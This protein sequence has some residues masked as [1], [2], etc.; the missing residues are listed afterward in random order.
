MPMSAPAS[1]EFRLPPPGGWFASIVGHSFLLATIGLA[2]WNLLHAT[3]IPWQTLVASVLWPSLIALWWYWAVGFDEGFER[4]VANRQSEFSRN[5]FV[6][7]SSSN[8]APQ[9]ISVGFSFHGRDRF[10]LDID[11]QGL[12]TISWSRGQASAMAERD[13]NDWQ[14]AL[15]CRPPEGSAKVRRPGMRDEDIWVF[16]YTGSRKKISRLG[17]SLVEFLRSC[18]LQ[19]EAGKDA[20]EYETPRRRALATLDAPQGASRFG[21]SLE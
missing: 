14:L 15:W 19:L 13:F 16:P 17:E 1:A 4:Y 12:S 21:S 11:A 18:G 9:R 20:C 3:T 10:L 8:G 6:R 5:H 7:V 2:G